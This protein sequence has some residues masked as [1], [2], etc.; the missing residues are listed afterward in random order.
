MGAKLAVFRRT[1]SP[2]LSKRGLLAGS[3]KQEGTATHEENAKRKVRCEL[4]FVN[5]ALTLQSSRILKVVE[6]TRAIPRK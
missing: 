4:G 2:K 5:I 6:M 3:K 1:C